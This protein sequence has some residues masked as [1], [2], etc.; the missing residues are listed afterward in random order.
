M[1]IKKQKDRFKSNWELSSARASSVLHY[2]VDK[3]HLDSKKVYMA[4]FGDQHPIA[5]NSTPAG[6]QKNRRVDIVIVPQDKT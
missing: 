6:R 5:N 2:M 1:P 4:G 3:G